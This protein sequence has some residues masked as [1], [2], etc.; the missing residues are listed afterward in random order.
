MPAAADFVL[1][2]PVLCMHG[3]GLFD[4]KVVEVRPRAGLETL[5]LV[6]Y[7]GW[8][9]NWDET[10]PEQRL[11][12][13][14]QEN[15][16]AKERIAAEIAA[17]K[18]TKRKVLEPPEPSAVPTKPAAHRK[19]TAADSQVATGGEPAAGSAAAA[20]ASG[21]G[22]DEL[23]RAEMKLI[24]PQ[25][26][27]I[28]LVADWEAV[29]REHKLVP[30][31]SSPSIAQILDEFCDAK[32]RR[33]QHERLY[34]EVRAGIANY[35]QQ[36]LEQALLYRFERKQFEDLVASAEHAGRPLE[37]L[38]GAEHLLRLLVKLPT[39]LEATKMEADQRIVLQAKLQEL[40]KFMQKNHAQFF[41]AKHA[42]PASDYLEW[43]D[44]LE[45]EDPGA[46]PGVAPAVSEKQVSKAHERDVRPS[47]R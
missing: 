9:K 23:E 30:L 18:G 36:A 37:E 27:K 2:E 33:S 11:R 20:D 35:F 45:T 13:R 44:T 47:R 31:P 16:E 43:W 39:Y 34:T 42:A 19:K 17:T 10:V 7:I 1:N 15:L 14:T 41:A 21:A 26:L 3:S 6:H 32:G 29:T 25:A 22:S 4:A 24:I 28:K 8:K 40:L 5:Y 46:K 38:F 12:K